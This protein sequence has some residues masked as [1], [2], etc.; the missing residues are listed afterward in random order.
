MAGGFKPDPDDGPVSSIPR[1]KGS[2]GGKPVRE[3]SILEIILG[4]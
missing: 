4:N 2:V 1:P 3:K